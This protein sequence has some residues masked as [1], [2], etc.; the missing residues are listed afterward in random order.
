MTKLTKSFGANGPARTF[1]LLSDFNFTSSPPL[2]FATTL[3][4]GTTFPFSPSV[5]VKTMLVVF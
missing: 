2:L 1:P 3:A 4:S 5:T